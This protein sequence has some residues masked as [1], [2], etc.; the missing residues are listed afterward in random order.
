[1]RPGWRGTRSWSIAASGHNSQLLAGI[2]GGLLGTTIAA[3]GR[4]VVP[5]GGQF[6]RRLA[7]SFAYRL[8]GL[9]HVGRVVV[10]AN[11]ARGA[12]ACS[13]LGASGMASSRTASAPAVSD[14]HQ[15]QRGEG[16]DPVG[17]SSRMKPSR[18]SPTRTV[19]GYS[20]RARASAERGRVQ[21][22]GRAEANLLTLSL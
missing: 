11:V 22:P 6:V 1:M 18:I 14:A 12:A 17:V 7:G 16:G 9:C 3:D 8:V 5:A 19:A 15:L 20:R 10:A 4:R 13:G 21:G 2:L